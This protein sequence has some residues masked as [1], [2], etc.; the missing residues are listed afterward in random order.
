MAVHE[1]IL[2][3][4]LLTQGIGFADALPSACPRWDCCPRGRNTTSDVKTTFPELKRGAG[5]DF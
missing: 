2:F 4:K 1:V 3:S 5:R